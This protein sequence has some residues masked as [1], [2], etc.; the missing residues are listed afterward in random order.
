MGGQRVVLEKL[1]IADTKDRLRL[2]HLEALA[3]GSEPAGR[4]FVRVDRKLTAAVVERD[5]AGEQHDEKN[6]C[7]NTANPTGG[8][9]PTHD[10]ERQCTAARTREVNAVDQ[11]AGGRR[12]RDGARR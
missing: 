8:E 5:N 4:G 1:P 6:S 10:R 3:P 11:N 12:Q 7:R 2:E 9:S